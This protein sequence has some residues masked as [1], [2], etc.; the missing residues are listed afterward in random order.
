VQLR[1]QAVESAVDSSAS[2]RRATKAYS[3]TPRRP[4]GEAGEDAV[5]STAW[6]ALPTG[7]EAVFE[8]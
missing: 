5:L 7:I 3:G 1:V 8:P 2:D 6:V 4:K